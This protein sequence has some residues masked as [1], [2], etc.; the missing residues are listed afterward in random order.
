[1]L[2]RSDLTGSGNNTLRLNT[3]DVLALSDDTSGGLIRL[4]V[5]GNVGDVVDVVDSGW[6]IVGTTTIGANA[7]SIYQNGNAQIIVDSDVTFG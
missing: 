3:L 5:H 4:T 2:F 1:M 6:A 7:Y